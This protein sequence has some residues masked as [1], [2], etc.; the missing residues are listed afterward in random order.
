MNG[1]KLYLESKNVEGVRYEIVSFDKDKKVATL[2][3]ETSGQMFP[4]YDFTK[5]RITELGYRL[6]Q[7]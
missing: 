4:I 6:V 7:L 1:K 2:K 3:S 5:E